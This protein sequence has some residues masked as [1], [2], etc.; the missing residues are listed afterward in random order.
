[1]KVYQITDDYELVVA[2]KQPL[3]SMDGFSELLPILTLVLK[4]ETVEDVL[5][6]QDILTANNYNNEL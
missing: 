5:K 3:E 1:M 4:P 6:I 2:E